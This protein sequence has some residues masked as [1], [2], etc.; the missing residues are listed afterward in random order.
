MPS[1]S[2]VCHCTDES[3]LHNT[4]QCVCWASLVML[5][6]ILDRLNVS[7][8]SLVSHSHMCTHTHTHTH[9]LCLCAGVTGGVIAGIVVPIVLV[10]GLTV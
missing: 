7:Y 8:S 2:R 4:G 10:V 6:V 9:T 1:P 3:I 5:S